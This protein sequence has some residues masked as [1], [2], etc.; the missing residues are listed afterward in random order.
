MDPNIIAFI[1][2]LGTSASWDGV[3]K[4]LGKRSAKENQSMTAVVDTMVEF[5][6]YMG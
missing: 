1:I 6:E 2:S 4:L 3:K 5:Y